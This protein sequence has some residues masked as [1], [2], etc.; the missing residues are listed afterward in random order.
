M[1]RRSDDTAAHPTRSHHFAGHSGSESSGAGRARVKVPSLSAFN[2]WAAADNGWHRSAP[3]KSV[4]AA[5][6]RCAQERCNQVPPQHRL[7]SL[8]E[9][10]E[11]TCDASSEGHSSPKSK[12]ISNGYI[13]EDVNMHIEG[14][15]LLCGRHPTPPTSTVGY[16]QEDA[17]ID[18]KCGDWSGYN[19]QQGITDL[20]SSAESAAR[21]PSMSDDASWGSCTPAST[22][23]DDRAV[24]GSSATNVESLFD[25][26]K[27]S[28]QGLFGDGGTSSLSSEP[29]L[30]E[31]CP[32]HERAKAEGHPLAYTLSTVSAEHVLVPVQSASLL[33]RRGAGSK[34]SSPAST[35][36]G[37][38]IVAAPKGE[39]VVWGGAL[40]E[41]SVDI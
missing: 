35:A 12:H 14:S 22:W 36:M 1:P 18:R 7:G 4:S 39:A 37:D 20:F 28:E 9:R 6:E 21:A 15:V 29:T 3:Q 19:Q 17:D 33:A 26:T 30:S 34:G 38:R 41:S 13:E 25:A 23:G 8:Q 11:G 5:Q 40:M 2:S 32:V 24:R 10:D 31:R 27:A 16:M